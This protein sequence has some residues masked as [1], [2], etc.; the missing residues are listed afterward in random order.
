MRPKL[1]PSRRPRACA[2]VASPRPGRILR[3]GTRPGRPCRRTCRDLRAR[4]TQPRASRRGRASSF[5][6]L[7]AALLAELLHVRD[8][9]PDLRAEFRG[10]VADRTRAHLLELRAHIGIR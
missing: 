9:A 1:V 6:E 8:L 4:R 2:R 10:R 3:P 7:E 5:V